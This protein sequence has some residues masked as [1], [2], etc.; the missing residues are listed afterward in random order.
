MLFEALNLD[1]AKSPRRWSARC[2]GCRWRA[3]LQMAE[4]PD[5]QYN[6]QL[7]KS[8]HYMMT[9]YALKNRPG[10]WRAGSIYVRNDETGQIVHEGAD[11]EL[12]PELMRELAAELNAPKGRPDL[13][14]AAMAHLNLTMIHPFRDGNGSH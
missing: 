9:N 10:R 4:D 12:V 3:V 6:D 2:G 7:T 8:L 11:L 14:R 5:F 13:I 1:A